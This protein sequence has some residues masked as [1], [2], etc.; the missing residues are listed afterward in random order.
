MD[1]HRGIEPFKDP[2]FFAQVR[3][4]PGAAT[5]IWPN[6][7]DMAPEPPMTRLLG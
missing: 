4:D 7:L 3:V 5:I 6:G 2:T 1:R